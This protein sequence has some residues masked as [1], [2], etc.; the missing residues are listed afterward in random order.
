MYDVAL[1]A[2][3]SISTRNTSSAGGSAFS[4]GV[5]VNRKAWCRPAGAVRY[6]VEHS[7]TAL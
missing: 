3:A 7:L 4:T 6:A 1:D 2:G 5:R